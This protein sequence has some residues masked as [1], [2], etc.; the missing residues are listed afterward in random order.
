MLDFKGSFLQTERYPVAQ[1]A[2]PCLE[3][4]GIGLVGLP[5]S[6]R[7]AQALLSESGAAGSAEGLNRL[8]IP[9]EKVSCCIRIRFDSNTC[10]RYAS[11]ILGGMLGF[12]KKPAMSVRPCPEEK[13]SPNTDSKS[14]FSKERIHSEQTTFL[15]T[16]RCSDSTATDQRCTRLSLF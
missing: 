16:L 1:A 11:P 4:D 10:A 12:R 6:P 7:D 14:W 3:I 5:L 15:W 8:E 2:N 13:S 9:A